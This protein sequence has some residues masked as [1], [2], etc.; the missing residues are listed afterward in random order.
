VLLAL[1][2]WFALRGRARGD[3]KYAGLRVLRR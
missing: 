3:E 1:L 2:A